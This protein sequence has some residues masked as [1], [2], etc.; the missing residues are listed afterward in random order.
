MVEVWGGGEGE[1]FRANLRGGGEFGEDDEEMGEDGRGE[2]CIE[3]VVVEGV[4][5]V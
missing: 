5:G 4:C 3:G 2:R 1:C